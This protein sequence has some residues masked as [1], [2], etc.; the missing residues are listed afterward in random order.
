MRKVALFVLALVSL[1]LI[2]WA[3]SSEKVI[4]HVPVKP[5]S[6][7]SGEEMYNNYC[8]SCHGKDL[9]GN[10]PAA[11]ALKVP[12]TDLTTLAQKAGGKFPSAKVAS[13]TKGDVDMPAHGSKEMPV[14]GPV[15]YRIS[16]GHES[17]VQLRISN[18]SKY[19]EEKQVK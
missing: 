10:G 7:A 16:S 14:W 19:I 3:Q 17:E 1:S 15:F 18:L 6:A 8:A 13:A 5:T 11:P 4:K 12:P 2:V 9:K